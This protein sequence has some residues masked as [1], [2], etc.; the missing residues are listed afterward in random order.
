MFDLKQT[1]EEPKELIEYDKY[2]VNPDLINKGV[3][4]FFSGNIKKGYSI[5]IPCF[6]RHFV[7]KE[8]ELY[9]LT[10]KKGEGK[11]TI[12]QAIQIMQSIVNGLVWVCAYQENK[13]WSQKIN[14]LDYL[15]GES[16]KNVELNNP[17]LY[18][19]ASDWVDKHFIFLKLEDISTALE[20][21]KHLID[22]GVKV[23]ALVLD[24]INSFISGFNTTG[25]GYADGV[26]AARKV[27]RFVE[28]YCT[29]YVSQ[30]PNMRAQR[31]DK[32]VTSY[33][34]EGG[35]WNN[36]ADTTWVINREAGTSLNNI[37]IENIR[38]KHTG[39]ERTHPED[40]LII[41][42]KMCIIDIIKGVEKHENVIQYLIRK[43]NPLNYD[44][45]YL[46]ETKE[47]ITATPE[48]AFEPTD[49]VPF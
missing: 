32:P 34:A 5:G 27:Q 10:G 44:H 22:T 11:T 15:L 12:N 3:K 23:H 31:E 49:G 20:V 45:E 9:A 19:K 47:I 40:P 8:N 17:K 41:E 25:N 18:K 29:V 33:D 30:H 38:N 21:T 13:D 6:D 42:W 24:P 43:H 26:E 16:A 2:I 37:G 7:C 14:Y 46:P 35:W 1:P 48:E 39:G 36:K 28:D 4:A